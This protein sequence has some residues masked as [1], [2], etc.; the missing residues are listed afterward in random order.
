MRWVFRVVGT[1]VLVLFLLILLKPSAPKSDKTA[2]AGSSVPHRPAETDPASRPSG[3][4]QRDASTLI[5]SKHARCR[6]GCRHISE[7]E[8]KDILLH[9]RINY[10]KSD[11]RGS[12]DPKYAVEGPTADGQDVRIVFAQSPRGV[13]VV[14]VIDLGREW[15]CDCK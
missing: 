13:V 9:G 5:F 8:V 4:L 10:Q 12:P 11:L 6:M 3:E 15:Q 1:L 14:T 2:P 7:A